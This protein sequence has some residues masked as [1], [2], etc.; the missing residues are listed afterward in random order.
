LRVPELVQQEKTG[1]GTRGEVDQGMRVISQDDP[2][3]HEPPE[4]LDIDEIVDPGHFTSSECQFSD[5]APATVRMDD[6]SLTMLDNTAAFEKKS[7]T[8]SEDLPSLPPLPSASR[9]T[10]DSGLLDYVSYISDFLL[11]LSSLSSLSQATARPASGPF[12]CP[13]T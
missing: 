11:A 10:D 6:S 7:R 1:E 5:D 4:D 13:S 9:R 2:R 8:S 12:G 3:S